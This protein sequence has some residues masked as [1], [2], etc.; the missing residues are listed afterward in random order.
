[1]DAVREE[2][3]LTVHTGESS[4]SLEGDSGRDRV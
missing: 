1:M 3:L 2:H 4:R